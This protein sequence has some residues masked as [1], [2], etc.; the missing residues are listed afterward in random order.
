MSPCPWEIR[1]GT[2]AETATQCDKEE[3]LDGAASNDELAVTLI[4]GVHD[5]G[6]E[7]PGLPEFPYQRVSWQATDR[8]EYTGEWPGYCGKLPGATFAGGCC[9]PAGHPGGCAP[10]SGFFPRPPDRT[11]P[12]RPAVIAGT[13]GPPTA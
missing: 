9:L 10:C 12:P 2:S 11:S 6:H 4:K 8:R 1:Y 5:T 3:H 13:P 7:G